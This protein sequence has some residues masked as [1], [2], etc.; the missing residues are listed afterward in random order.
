MIVGLPMYA[1]PELAAPT[2][3]WWRGLRRH[4][5]RAG[6]AEVP[7]R[8]TEPSD[9]ARHW[10]APD[11]LFTQTCGYPLTH[12]LSGKVQLVATPCFGAAGC[13]GPSYCSV[14]VTRE[15]EGVDTLA[16][17]RGKRVAYNGTDSQSGYNTLRHL[18]APMAQAGRFFAAGIETGA[19]RRS[20]AAVRDGAADVAALDCVSL[21]LIERVAPDELSG[22]RKLCLTSPAPSLPYIASKATP[23]ETL[24]RLRDGL[25]AATDD[26]HLQATRAALLLTDIV[27]LPLEAYHSILSMEREAVAAG[28]PRLD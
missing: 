13:D 18:V 9:L 23:A 22:I 27:V 6:I 2:R 14:V 3:D 4:F 8:L 16:D 25:R 24:E 7:E 21:A 20:L 19:H 5:M 26:P 1:L 11:L 28:Y 10:L 15:E 12:V 17:L